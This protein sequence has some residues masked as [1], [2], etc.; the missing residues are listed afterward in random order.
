MRM[1]SPI[2]RRLGLLLALLS[3]TGLH[4]V[5]QTPAVFPARAVTLVVPFP[6]GGGPDLA[7]RVMAEKLATRWGQPV[8]IDN[9]PGAGALL[10]AA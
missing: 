4:A 5:A 10:G 7:A 9:K 1:S 3:W 8:V 6:P 2:S